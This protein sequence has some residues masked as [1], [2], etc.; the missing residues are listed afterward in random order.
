MTEVELFGLG[1]VVR[2]CYSLV[3]NYFISCLLVGVSWLLAVI[4]W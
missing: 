4:R 3:T 1:T 2:N